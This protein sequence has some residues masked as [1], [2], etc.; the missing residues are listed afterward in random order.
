MKTSR[1]RMK[2]SYLDEKIGEQLQ[3]LFDRGDKLLDL[4]AELRS[5]KSKKK[6]LNYIARVEETGLVIIDEVAQIQTRLRAQGVI[7]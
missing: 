2:V 3:S 6:D 4:A 5:S 7:K 1:C